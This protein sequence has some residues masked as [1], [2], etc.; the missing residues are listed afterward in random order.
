MGRLLVSQSTVE[1]L[2]IVLSFLRTELILND[3]LPLHLVLFI[4]FLHL[5]VS[6]SRK[7]RLDI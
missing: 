4:F 7:K 6:L 5:P 1:S 2:S 3:D